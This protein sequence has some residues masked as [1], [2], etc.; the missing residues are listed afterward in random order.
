MMPHKKKK[1]LKRNKKKSLHIVD[2]VI[3]TQHVVERTNESGK[4][5][6][7][8]NGNGSH[9]SHERESKKKY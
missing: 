6:M 4:L 8:D 5:N 7:N 2:V 3:V 1:K 9:E